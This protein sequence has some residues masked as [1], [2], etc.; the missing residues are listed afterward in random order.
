MAHA[1][2]LFKSANLKLIK[3]ENHANE[4]PLKYSE[5][6]EYVGHRLLYPIIKK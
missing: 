1:K 6:I 5:K 3:V 2:I 4:N